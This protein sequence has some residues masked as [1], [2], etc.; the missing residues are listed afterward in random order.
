MITEFNR[1]NLEPHTALTKLFDELTNL[2]NIV[3]EH[4]KLQ[5]DIKKI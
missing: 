5:I 3:P 1:E 4:T 2:R